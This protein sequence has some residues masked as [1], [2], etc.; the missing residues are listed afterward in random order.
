MLIKKFH[1]EPWL[2][3]FMKSQK[4]VSGVHIEEFPA[5]PDNPRRLA[6]VKN[7]VN[8]KDQQFNILDTEVISL[9]KH[10]ERTFYQLVVSNSGLLSQVIQ[11]SHDLHKLIL[12]HRSANF[13]FFF[14]LP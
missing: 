12:T 1:I 7:I 9:S 3:L 11:V 6:F 10:S 8:P 2:Q 14:R 4:P 5:I 13:K